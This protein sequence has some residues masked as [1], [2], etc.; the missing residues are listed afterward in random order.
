MINV[1][2]IIFKIQLENLSLYFSL[3]T[4]KNIRSRVLFNNVLNKV[5][6]SRFCFFEL[7]DKNLPV[8]N[9]ELLVRRNINF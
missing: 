7:F 6:F 9:Y 4:L 3:L 5:I 8:K 2:L 1:C